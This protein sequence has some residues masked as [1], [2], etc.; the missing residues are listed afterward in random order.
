[1]SSQNNASQHIPH[2]SI[3]AFPA[4]PTDQLSA[5]EMARQLAWAYKIIADQRA[6]LKEAA[7]QVISLQDKLFISE[8]RAQT[9]FFPLQ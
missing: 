2:N 9:T 5:L 1:M 4:P 8:K 3:G 6:M 7:Q